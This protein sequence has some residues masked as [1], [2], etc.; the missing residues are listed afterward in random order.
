MKISF[1]EK[2]IL[3]LNETKEKVIK[4]DIIEDVFEEDMIRRLKYI[5]EHKYEISFDRLKKEWD[6]KLVSNGV[7]M[8]PTDR[9]EYAE[10]VF[11]QPNYKC[12]KKREM[13]GK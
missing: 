3:F 13:E 6:E 10:L 7:S 2:E 4:N 5:I 9:D 1:N 11:S 12:R 8:V